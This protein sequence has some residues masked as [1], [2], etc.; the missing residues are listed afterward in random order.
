MEKLEPVGYLHHNAE[1][2]RP[3][4]HFKKT[5]HDEMRPLY[6]EQD[7][8][9]LQQRVAELEQFLLPSRNAFFCV[10]HGLPVTPSEEALMW[11]IQCVNETHEV[12]RRL[13]EALVE[14]ANKQEAMLAAVINESIE[15]WCPTCK[16]IH[17]TQISGRVLQPCPCCGDTMLPTSYNLREIKRLRKRYVAN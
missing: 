3:E 13:F 1:Y 12:G 8:Q 5:S 2:N 16:I 4:F 15:W 14:K 6:A 7:V 9:K 10:E 17:P 11:R